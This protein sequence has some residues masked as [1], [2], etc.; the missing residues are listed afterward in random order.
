[1]GILDFEQAGKTIAEGRR[2]AEYALPEIRRSIKRGKMVM[3]YF[4][5]LPRPRRRKDRNEFAR[6]ERFKRKLGQNAL[7][8]T[9]TDLP[10]FEKAFCQHLAPDRHLFDDAPFRAVLVRSQAPR[11]FELDGLRRCALWR[12]RHRCGVGF[13]WPGILQ[14]PENGQ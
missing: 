14:E 10:A 4:A 1:M 8:H 12:H 3:V 9:Y 7:Y 6:V 2:T 11:C 5:N 13:P